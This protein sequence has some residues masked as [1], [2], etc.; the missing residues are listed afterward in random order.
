MANIH[1]QRK[2]ILRSERE[3]LENRRY[4]S[5]IKTYFRRLEEA[6][7]GGDDTLAD[8]EQARLVQLIDKAIK[9]GAIHR[10]NGARKKARAA[11]L[12]SNSAA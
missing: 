5:A 7:K 9:R 11:R 2:R 10:N 6:V 4:T 8:T 1:S 3:R 12:R